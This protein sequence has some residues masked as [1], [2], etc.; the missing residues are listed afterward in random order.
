MKE[1]ITE[2][3]SEMFTENEAH[4]TQLSKVKD[5][6]LFSNGDH[7]LIWNLS[8]TN[9]DFAWCVTV[10]AKGS[11]INGVLQ[12]VLTENYHTGSRF[13]IYKYNVRTMYP[14]IAYTKTVSCPQEFRISFR[15][16]DHG[17]KPWKAFLLNNNTS[18]SQH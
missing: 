12:I 6:I 9:E 1:T 16:N 10:S 4:Y 14:E 17:S 3:H 18:V 8:I 7:V 11:N 2:L 15:F 13:S 5:H